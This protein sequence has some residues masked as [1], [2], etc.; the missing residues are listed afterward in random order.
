MQL[1][2]LV[3][4][5]LVGIPPAR[6]LA[7]R[8]KLS[9]SESSA[10]VKIGLAGVVT[11]PMFWVLA[12]SD[13][14]FLLKF[15]G[16]EAVGIYSIG[17]SVGIVGLMINTAVMSVWQPE[18]AR[19]YEEDPGRARASLGSL[20]SRLMAAMAVIWL[21]I[22][23]AG[24]DIVRLLANERF[25]LAADYVPYIAGGV[26]FYGVLRLATTGLLLAKRL[27]WSAF[28]WLSGG[29]VC[30]VLNL[31]LV[32]TYGGMG[33]AV[34]QTISFAFIAV[35]ILATAQA[36]FRVQLNTVRLTAIATGV[37]AAGIYMARPWH[38]L[39][40]VSLLIKLPVGLAIGFAV[41]AVMAPDSFTKAIDHLRQRRVS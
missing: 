28:W 10:L 26:Y 9:W 11:A 34:T 31:I 17:Y 35:G 41:A 24:G 5:F 40:A 33:A 18:A 32:P 30:A 25:H 14:W 4:I 29:L 23:A 20:M 15:Q 1:S 27:A 21:A 7:R 3:P 38:S 8:S 13:R 37:L 19:E 2:Y 16:P 39:P 22:T 6:N 12:S 36:T